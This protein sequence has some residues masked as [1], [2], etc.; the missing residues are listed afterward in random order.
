[1]RQR[2]SKARGNALSVS[3]QAWEAACTKCL[4]VCGSRVITKQRLLL[5][6][7]MELETTGAKSG[8]YESRPGEGGAAK[9]LKGLNE[10][11]ENTDVAISVNFALYKVLS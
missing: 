5:S 3:I 2:I 7:Q 6:A 10:N 9:M 4:G 8:A 1:M 11:C